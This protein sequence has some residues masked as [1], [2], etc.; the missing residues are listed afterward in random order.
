MSNA[1]R[2]RELLAS[3]EA[4]QERLRAAVAAYEGDRDEAAAFA[5]LV[6]PLAAVAGLPF[7]FEEAMAV[8]EEDREVS[9]DDADAVAGGEDV[10]SYGMNICLVIGIGDE[11]DGYVCTNGIEGCGGGICNYIGSGFI[12]WDS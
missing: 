10:P 9:L 5:A 6:A 4:L 11:T 7:T 12:G 8:A 1:E 2:F 3:D